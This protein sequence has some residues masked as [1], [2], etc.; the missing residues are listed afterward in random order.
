MKGQAW[1]NVWEPLIFQPKGT[2]VERNCGNWEVCDEGSRANDHLDQWSSED[3]VRLLLF[4][5]CVSPSS[6]LTPG[7]QRRFQRQCPCW[8]MAKPTSPKG[9]VFTLRQNQAYTFTG[10]Y[11]THKIPQPFKEFWLGSS[12]PL[13]SIGNLHDHSQRLWAPGSFLVL[14]FKN[15][16]ST[17]AAPAR[18]SAS[19]NWDW[20]TFQ[21]QLQDWMYKRTR[22]RTFLITELQPAAS[23]ASRPE[24]SGLGQW[25]PSTLLWCPASYTRPARGSQMWPEN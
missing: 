7:T 21:S 13:S 17:T 25:S 14:R 10:F 18:P 8:Q 5:S 19:R 9:K 3:P 4:T 16:I 15:K 24:G 23:A 22:A 20:R 11:F 2:I 1:L 6:Q 12:S